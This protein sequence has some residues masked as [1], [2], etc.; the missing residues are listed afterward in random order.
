MRRNN[1]LTLI[2]V[3]IALLI[4]IIIVIGVLSYMYA[5]AMNARTADVRITATRVGQLLLETWKL[6]GHYIYDESGNITGWSWNVT[7]FD[8]TDT[9]FN[10]NLPYNFVISS[11]TFDE[12]P[13]GDELGD[14]EVVIDDKTYFLTLSYKDDNPYMLTVRVVWSRNSSSGSISSDDKWID[15]TSYAIF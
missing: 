12:E 7:D 4:A 10:D 5:C 11:L 1:A 9:V 15:V 2:E 14:Y 3:M 6:T 8:P 13:I